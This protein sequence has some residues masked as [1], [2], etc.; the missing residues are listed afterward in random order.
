VGKV[1]LAKK[2][3]ASKVGLYYLVNK[4]K[5]KNYILI[6][7]QM[8]TKHLSSLGAEEISRNEFLKYLI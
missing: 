5:S 7:C 6:D 4:L 8:Y 2:K 1:C 3:D